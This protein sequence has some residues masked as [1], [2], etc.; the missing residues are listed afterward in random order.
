MAKI[1]F[2]R[3]EIQNI[4]EQNHLSAMVSY[5]EREEE[6]IF[7]ENYIIYLRISTSSNIY[8]DDILHIRKVNIQVTHFHKIKLDSI[9]ELMIANFRV[10]PVTSSVRQID[11]DFWATHYRF[12]CLTK[13][14]W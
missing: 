13:G 5:L 14:A 3:E 6:L 1:F 10:T 7:P 2:T 9:E 11:T 8:A 4:L 12:E